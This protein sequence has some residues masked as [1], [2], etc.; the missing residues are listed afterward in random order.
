MANYDEYNSHIK[1]A[2]SKRTAQQME[3]ASQVKARVKRYYDQ[4]EKFE[5]TKEVVARFISM[6]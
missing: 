1:E 4:K 5:K 3:Q 2:K 6:N